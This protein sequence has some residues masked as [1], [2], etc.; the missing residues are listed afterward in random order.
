M[1][2]Q[3]NEK[4]NQINRRNSAAYSRLSLLKIFT[5]QIWDDA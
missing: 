3:V 4:Q 5:K 2:S 1:Q